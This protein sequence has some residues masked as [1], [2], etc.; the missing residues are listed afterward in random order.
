MYRL[1]TVRLARS[2][3]HLGWFVT[4][5]EWQ[6]GYSVRM[7]ILRSRA[8]TRSIRYMCCTFRF[9]PLL[10]TVS[11]GW[12][13]SADWWMERQSMYLHCI[14]T[15]TTALCHLDIYAQS[16]CN[17]TFFSSFFGPSLMAW[18]NK[19]M[20]NNIRVMRM[21]LYGIW[22]WWPLSIILSLPFPPPPPPSPRSPSTYPFFLLDQG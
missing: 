17:Y 8:F 13:I 21:P 1:K 4:K 2:H 16:C 10:R 22:S 20:A 14:F 15:W 5:T 18:T 12:R 11:L 3:S 9:E 7:N 19:T 6:L